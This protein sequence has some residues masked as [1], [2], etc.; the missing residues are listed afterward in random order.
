M[1]EKLKLG[2]YFPSFPIFLEVGSGS[3]LVRM[4]Q[5]TDA[6]MNRT[7]LLC[8]CAASQP[9]DA[10]RI[11]AATGRTVS[12]VHS[13]L[14]TTE[15]EQVL[16]ALREGEIVIACG[17]EAAR[18]GAMAA[19]V[20]RPVPQCVDIRDRAGW[21]DDADPAPKQAALLAEALLPAAETPVM[22]VESGGTVLVVGDAG[23]ALAAAEVLSRTMAV[24]V[25]LPATPD[26]VEAPAAFQVVVG[27]LAGVTGSLGR[28]SVRIDR[29][30]MLDP[31]GR[32]PPRFTGPRD[33]ARSNCD[34]VVDLSGDRPLFPAHEKRDGYLRADPDSPRAVAE[35]LA[36][37]AQMVGVF[38]KPLHIRVDPSSCAHSRASKTGCTRCLNVCPTG[39]LAPEGD[40]VVVDP[41][42]CA[43]CGGCS[44]VCPSGAITCETPPLAH[45]LRRL[46]VLAATYRR[47]G[48]RSPRLLVHDDHGAQMI[49]LSARSG[50]GLP[51]D[52]LPLEI[53]ALNAFGHAEALASL[54]L[55][56]ASVT[57]LPGPRTEVGP[58]QDE[59]A[60]ARA[61]G[62]GD[63]LSLLDVADPD[64]LSDVLYDGNTPDPVA[65]VLPMGNR[66][67]I[68]RLSARALGLTD[69]VPLPAGA[70]YGEV[71]LDRGACTLCLSCVSLCPSGALMDNPERPQ[72]RF[73][74]D[75]CLQ[76]GLCVTICPE[77]AIGLNPR[78]DPR[79]GALSARIL[80]EEEP[81]ACIECGKPFG[82]AS[83]IRR[84]VEKLEGQHPM[85]AGS[86][87]SRL[88]RMCEDCRVEAHFRG[89]NPMAM[90]LRRPRTTEDYLRRDET[91]E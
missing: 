79:D 22:D 25:L 78:F 32:G 58:L 42:V 28:F 66:R 91:D 59:L 76:C 6:S 54:A 84:I 38:E 11:A 86:V 10:D 7:I 24:T 48:G 5:Q 85:F 62:A 1:Q 8:N 34:V 21:S 37:A 27:R 39:A 14:C 82:T 15:M 13:A 65:P 68:A 60:L 53:T 2:R 89:E 4:G 43:G 77:G 49:R 33:G 64:G 16:T 72:L 45:L 50:R 19:G 81:F 47:A 31:A 71:V 17:Q 88:I 83:T 67:Q 55:G 29:L 80:H 70:P 20:G 41:H 30:Q 18:F 9:V 23:P 75:A 51:A 63:R 46:E 56:F 52:V 87:Q 90:G 69:P 35:L 3:C 73:Q 74:E 44:S 26:L 61:M 57:V 12:R 36:D 40:H